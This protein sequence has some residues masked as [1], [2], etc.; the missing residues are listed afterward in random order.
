MSD[1]EMQ[2]SEAR[3]VW[4]RKAPQWGVRAER[5]RKMGMPVSMLM[6]ESIAPQPGQR[7]LELAAG[8]GD[9]GFLAAE[10]LRPSGTL[11]S[12]DMAD[13]MVD[14]ARR[15]AQ[16]L[17]IDNVEFRRLELEWIDL[18]AASVDGVLCRWGL[19]LV[20]DPEAALREI[21]RVL[22]PGGRV[23]IAVWGPPAGNPWA[24]IPTDVLVSKGHAEPPDRS[25]PGMFALADIPRLKALFERAGFTEVAV[26]PVAIERVHKSVEDYLAETMDLSPVFPLVVENLS[27]QERDAVWAAVA[28]ASK[29]FTDAAGR[30]TLPGSSLVASA[31]A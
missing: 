29:P 23:A 9:T 25:G 14:V 30:V 12:S 10:L 31:T 28:D 3:E 16:E 26:E 17:G 19:M 1:A 22:K 5:L 2:R 24:T 8:P 20:L 4:E 18:E 15:R 27:D 21:R 13:A 11:I 7:V 6:I